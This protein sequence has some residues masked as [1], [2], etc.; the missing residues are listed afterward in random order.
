M[1][2]WFLL[3]NISYLVHILFIIGLVGS[4]IIKFV[5]RFSYIA[6]FAAPLF[7]I[8]FLAGVYLEGNLNGT[9]NY[10]KAVA[11][12]NEKIKEAEGKSKE[13]NERIKTVYVDRVQIIKEKGKDNVK[14]IEKVVTK[15]DNMC[16]LSNA[17]IGVHNS[18]SQ[19][20]VARSTTGTDE[21]A[22]DVKISELLK[23]IND[24]YSIYYQT[25]EQ[26][27]AWQTWYNEQKKIF[28]S[29]K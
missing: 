9:S 28:E 23:T 11:A 17:A 7:Y 2:E 22:S 13:V 4:I 19:N 5:K 6:K 25:R 15:Y 20:E 24:N 3:N 26:V 18:A 27:I 12:F 1:F 16:T 14:Y 10:L 29:V 21:G 8:L